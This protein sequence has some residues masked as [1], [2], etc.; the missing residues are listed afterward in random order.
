VWAATSPRRRTNRTR[1]SPR[2]RCWLATRHTGRHVWW[3]V[4]WRTRRT[5]GSRSSNDHARRAM[6]CSSASRRPHAARLGGGRL[7][8]YSDGKVANRSQGSARG[9]R[10]RPSNDGQI[11]N[12]RGVRVHVST[13]YNRGEGNRRASRNGR[14]S[15]LSRP[16]PPTFS[17]LY[18]TTPSDGG[19]GGC[20]DAQRVLG[21]VRAA[22]HARGGGVHSA[23]ELRGAVALAT[24]PRSARRRCDEPSGRRAH[25]VPH[26]LGPQRVSGGR[27]Q[28]AL[29]AAVR[30]RI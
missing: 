28:P 3:R 19:G 21:R 17:S 16:K 26:Q 13:G 9:D 11:P 4:W 15:D 30:P 2:R 12:V 24:A 22:V 14:G 10:N 18:D 20:G 5:G 23:Q 7:L 27:L 8:G 29:R 1:A 6:C 25:H